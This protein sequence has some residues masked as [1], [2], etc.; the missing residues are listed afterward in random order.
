MADIVGLIASVLQ[1]VDTVV[2][3]H[4]YIQDFRDAPKDQRQLL[5]EIRN[6]EPLIR[7]LD[8]RIEQKRATG[9]LGGI[10]E[11]EKSLIQLKAV[12]ERLVK[13]LDVGGIRKVVS[14]LTWSL[15][16][17]ENIHER[18]NAIERFK[19]LL[20]AWLS[21]DLH[22]SAQDITSAVN[23]AVD[24]QQVNHL[25]TIKSIKQLGRDQRVYHQ[26]TMS[27]LKDAVEEQRI[28]SNYISKSVKN[29]AQNQERYQNS[30]ERNMIIEWYSPLNF[31]LRQADILATCQPGTGRW[32]LQTQTFKEWKSGKGGVLWCHGMPGAGK[33]VLLSIVVDHLRTDQDI[34]NT[35]VAVI[36]LNHK[37]TD[38]R[39]PSQLLA[40][41]WRQ[42]VF[43][44]SIP[45]HL[46]DL[47]KRHCE[48]RTRPSVD[49]DRAVLHST[50]SEYSKVFVLVDAMDEYPEEHRNTL[51]HLLCAL[52]P[53]VNL[54]LTSRPHINIENIVPTSR[55]ETLEIRATEEDVRKYLDGQILKSSRLRNHIKNS[56][57]LRDAIEEKIVQRSDGMF[58]L[59]KLHIDSLAA[60]QSVKAVRNALRTMPNDLEHT[61]NEVVDRIDRQSEED[62]NLAW[63]TLCWITHAKRPLRPPELREALAVEP[64]STELDPENLLDIDTILS[65]CAGLVI[66]NKEDDTIRLIHYTMQDY[67][68][69]IQAQ[70]FP[71]ASTQITTTCI[72]YLTFEEL[73]KDPQCSY[74][75]PNHWDE[76]PDNLR[77]DSKP[78][79]DK[80]LLEYAVEYCLIHARG[81]PESSIRDL[82]LSFLTN[83]HAWRDLWNRHSG[84]RP[85]I[86]GTATRLWIAAAFCMEETCRY[87]IK[88]DGDTSLWPALNQITTRGRLDGVRTLIENGALGFGE[89]CS[90][91]LLIASSHGHTEIV[92]LLLNHGI[93]VNHRGQYHYGTAL[94]MAAFFGHMECTQLLI[95]C[96]AD[97]NIE[98]GCYGTALY[99]ASSQGWNLLVQMLL[100]NGAEVNTDSGSVGTPL[101]V[102]CWE[103]RAAS[104]MLL[105]A[106]G[107]DIDA[108]TGP[109]G[110]P[111]QASLVGYD[112]VFRLQH[113]V[114]VVAKRESRFTWDE[115]WADREAI[116]RFL[117]EHGADIN[118]R[119]GRY[120]TPLQAA[121]WTGHEVL[122][123]L[124]IEQG[125]HVN[126]KGIGACG[127]ALEAA[128][129]NGHEAI[130][131]LLFKHGA[132]INTEGG[133]QGS[134]LR[135]AASMG[136]K[137]IVKLLI[138]QGA[139]LREDH[140]ALQ[141]ASSAGSE[142]I[143]RLLIE[144]GTP[145]NAQGGPFGSALQ[146]ASSA[147]RKSIVK[148]LIEHGADVKGDANA[149]E[150][151]AA[152]GRREIVR[153][154]VEN[155][156]NIKAK[157]ER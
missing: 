121:S 49:E 5:L 69:R 66:M 39:T 44:K 113:E 115:S 8:K 43:G 36:Y 80:A 28:G 98:G 92:R 24:E 25:Y 117:V 60:K 47:H 120:A 147:G 11:L 95:E 45:R 42:L 51:L 105:V 108:K 123:R 133:K 154:L 102:A 18:L 141:A 2:R 153:L 131:K 33:T 62:R 7:E 34:E 37:E 23:D 144:H 70:T 132:D 85:E 48:T 138:E 137:A 20:N 30:V 143:V 119:I 61:Y 106:H 126:A 145:I 21:M 151:A 76:G 19:S 3:A 136:R 94:Q 54:M 114:D 74:P 35:G 135:A 157:R 100:E 71:H 83:C 77:L 63:L 38:M 88:E 57:D 140:G 12:M 14:R 112:T 46:G 27:A 10:Q 104:V 99:A 152:A 82:I 116:A 56:P 22:E 52:G 84:S 59:A 149:L 79:R 73:N 142:A 128:S 86:P 96:G 68:E 146:A 72:T 125:A 90:C 129:R 110:S 89:E 65:V 107:A 32:L 16:G 155:G 150:A 58:L 91:A 9:S 134:A 55:L 15:W 111:L 26:D 78:R 1:L 17:K 31:F 109:C 97:V 29:V 148:L 67:L 64:G 40:S 81:Q 50:I 4:D 127:T 75:P 118:A 6:L 139:L 103:G 122:T 13:K 101:Q 156:A 53:A 93:D 130:L 87:L 41:L 124:L